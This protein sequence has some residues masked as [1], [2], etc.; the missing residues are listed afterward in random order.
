MSKYQRKGQQLAALFFVGSLLFNYPLLSLFST[1]GLVGG[2]P[3]L[4]VYIFTIWAALIG[5][6]AVT[7]EF[8]K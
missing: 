6:M 3:I 2:I 1:E 7:I 8:R 4:Y 5:F